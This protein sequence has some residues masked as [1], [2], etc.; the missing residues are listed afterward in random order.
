MTEQEKYQAEILEKIEEV[1]KA[2]HEGDK[3][4][5]LYK[6]GELEAIVKFNGPLAA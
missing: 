2:T 5:T 1:A 4:K 3:G 6:L